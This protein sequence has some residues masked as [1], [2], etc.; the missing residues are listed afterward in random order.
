MSPASTPRTTRLVRAGLL[1]DRENVDGADLVVQLAGVLEFPGSPER[2]GDVRPR[3]RLGNVAR[4]AGLLR[5]RHRM[6]G[7]ELPRDGTA[8]TNRGDVL[9]EPIVRRHDDGRGQW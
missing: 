1:R 7:L 5:E 3:W 8:D 6:S 4:S 9:D 2:P